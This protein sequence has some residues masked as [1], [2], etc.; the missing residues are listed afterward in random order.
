[1]IHCTQCGRP[2]ADG[3]PTQHATITCR[4]C[5][6]AITGGPRQ[7][8]QVPL[9]STVPVEA[10]AL[11]RSHRSRVAAGLLGVFL[12]HLGV[13]RF[14]LGYIGV[15]VLQILLTLCTC[16]VGGLWGV[17]EGFVCLGGGMRDAEG[18]PLR[19]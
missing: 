11:G 13:H 2:I 1:M 12:G 4:Y 5:G 19:E 3:T 15:G 6:A 9:G 17:I 16:G 10:H 18:R 8:A 14:Y 7:V